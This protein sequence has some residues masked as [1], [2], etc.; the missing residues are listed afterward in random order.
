MALRTVTGLPVT[1]TIL[2]CPELSRWVK[3]WSVT[4]ASSA[5]RD[6]SATR[7]HRVQVPGP[8]EQRVAGPGDQLD[9]L[10]GHQ[11]ADL[12][13]HRAEDADLGCRHPVLLRRRLGVQVT[14]RD[15]G[16]RAFGG[17]R[18]AP[19]HPH[20]GPRDQHRA[21]DHRHA[22]GGT[23]VGDQVPGGVV[24]DRVDDQVVAAQHLGGVAGV[25]ADGVTHVTPGSS[26]V[27]PGRGA[28][29]LGRPIPSVEWSTWRCR[30]TSSTSSASTTPSVP[31][32]AA[33]R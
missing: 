17:A 32:P 15:P 20:L 11:R 3:G 29:G 24:V 2:A 21:P 7:R 4:A 10:V 28:D 14:Q 9:R 33:A 1:S 31:T 27:D 12:A 30:F 26:S 19:E 6:F 5:E 22:E 13:A 8:A 18:A 25:E 16:H 23:G